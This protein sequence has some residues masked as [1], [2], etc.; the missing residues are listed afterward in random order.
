MSVMA[1][2][3]QKSLAVAFQRADHPLAAIS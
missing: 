1:I 3:Q 2:Y